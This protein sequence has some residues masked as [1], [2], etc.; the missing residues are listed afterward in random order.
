MQLCHMCNSANGSAFPEGQCHICKGKTMDT[1]R[2]IDE[3]KA[4]LAKEAVGSF[5]ISTVIPKEWLV[6]EEEVW[7][8]KADDS[9]SIKNLLNRTI[10][11]ALKEAS[12]AGYAAE[13]GCRLVFDYAKGSVELQRNELFVFGRYRKISAGLSQ[14]R[15]KCA[16]CDGKGCAQC[17]GKGKHYD[18]VEEKIGEPFKKAAQARD[19]VMHASGREDV[20]ATNSGGRPFVLEIMAPVVRKLDLGALKEEIGKCGEVSVDGLKVVPRG[21]VE[22]VTESHFDKTYRAEV[23]FGREIGE[24][25]T[26]RVLSLA[27]R[28]ILQ[29]TPTRVV[30]RRADLVRH[31]KVK[32]IGID[33][34]AGNRATL[35]IKAEA[36][37]YI[38]ELISGDSGRTE[39]NIA[40]LL[41]TSATCRK[42]DVSKIE[43]GFLDFCLSSQR[44]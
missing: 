14:S 42:L 37:T 33:E 28:T 9:E 7:D 10:A 36:G 38:K 41:G 44:I 19:Y 3:A 24:G 39:P 16:R 23:E 12:G 29:Q 15:W 17:G 22:V 31:R 6:R 20:D 5:S 11:S 30:H 43:D 40:G 4:L 1:S 8:R 2:M 18:S 32:A 13:G 21:F 34:A 25:D 26:V 27:G 35:V